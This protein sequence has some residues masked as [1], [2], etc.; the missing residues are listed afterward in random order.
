MGI[1]SDIIERCL[2]HVPAKLIRTYQVNTR[3]PERTAALEAWDRHLSS[4]L[5]SE[6]R[7]DNV[8][9]MTRKA[10]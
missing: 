5:T 4:I 8:V 10:G 2:N 9:P 1:S 7:R 6:Q 3:L